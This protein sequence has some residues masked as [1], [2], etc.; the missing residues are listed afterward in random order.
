MM[1]QAA[2]VPSYMSDLEK[3]PRL[4]AWSKKCEIWEMQVWA[5]ELALPFCKATK[6]FQA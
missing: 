5:V 1:I 4:I 6:P 3:V 2:L